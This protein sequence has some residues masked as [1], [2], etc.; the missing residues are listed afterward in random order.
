MV[1]R[2]VVVCGGVGADGLFFF[3]LGCFDLLVLEWNGLWLC[4]ISMSPNCSDI[5]I[6]VVKC[7]LASMYS[8]CKGTYQ[9]RY[10]E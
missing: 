8:D 2:G 1:R 9:W 4:M 6:M 5:G 10:E 3:D 7:F